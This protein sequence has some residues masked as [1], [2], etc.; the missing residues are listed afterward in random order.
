[1]PKPE[2]EPSATPDLLEAL[3]QS[4]ENVQSGRAPRAEPEK[5]KAKA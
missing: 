3:R 4:L 5:A 1:M 2:K